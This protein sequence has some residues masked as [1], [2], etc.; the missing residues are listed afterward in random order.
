M[1]PISAVPKGFRELVVFAVFSTPLQGFGVWRQGNLWGRICGPVVYGHNSSGVEMN[2]RQ[3]L[4]PL[5][6]APEVRTGAA[7]AH[8]LR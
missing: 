8:S 5:S 4:V 3:Q 1:P 6:T 2:P 7:R